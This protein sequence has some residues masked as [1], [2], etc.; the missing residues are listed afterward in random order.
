MLIFILNFCASLSIS[1]AKLLA[2]F[3]SKILLILLIVPVLLPDFSVCIGSATTHS[4]HLSI[5]LACSQ[6]LIIVSAKLELLKVVVLL[7]ELVDFLLLLLVLDNSSGHFALGASG[8][9][10]FLWHT[11]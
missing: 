4:I 11:E 10:V 7:E 1:H 9:P 8:F 3:G 5:D 2:Q 6:I